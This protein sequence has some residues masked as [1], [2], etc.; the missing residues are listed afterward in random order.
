[1]YDIDVLFLLIF[2]RIL[3]AILY[4]WWKGF[5]LRLVRFE[6]FFDEFFFIM[7]VKEYEIECSVMFFV[8]FH[9][10]AERICNIL[11]NVPQS[12]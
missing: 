4:V 11:F 2:N 8:F 6:L 9:S 5:E 12:R 1:M 10:L 7:H 3:R